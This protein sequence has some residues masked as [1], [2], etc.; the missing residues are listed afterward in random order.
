[1]MARGRGS[2]ARMVQCSPDLRAQLASVAV[3][4]SSEGHKHLSMNLRAAKHRFESY[5]KPL[6]RSIRWLPRLVKLMAKV[7]HTRT[8][9]PKQRAT[10]WLKWLSP[11]R[12]LL[13]AMAAD[14]ADEAMLVTRVFDKEQFDVARV[15]TMLSDFLCRIEMLFGQGGGCL[16]GMGFTRF[17][18][19]TLS[20]EPPVWN[21]GGRIYS[22]QEPSE[23]DCQWALG[24]MRIWCRLAQETIAAEFPAYEISQA[25]RVFNLHNRTAAWQPSDEYYEDLARLAQVCGCNSAGLITEI[26]VLEPAARREYA[27]ISCNRQ[28][29]QSAWA[30]WTKNQAHVRRSQRTPLPNLHAVLLRYLAFTAST[31]G[32]EQTFTLGMRACT[33][34]QQSATERYEE[35]L[36]RLVVDSPGLEKTQ[37]LH[38]ASRMYSQP[39]D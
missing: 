28:A 25:F 10:A 16:R 31:S 27:S 20:R 24:R 11:R 13:A 22:L 15:S 29:W 9:T 12:V 39:G 14:A 37:L 26:G 35:T 32:V 38:N 17:I 8:G 18:V 33:V 3:R 7:S 30:H 21:L 1:M 2:A 36:M 5:S 19:R 6:G 4:R 23:D 34:F